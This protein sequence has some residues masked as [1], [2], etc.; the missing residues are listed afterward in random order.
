MNRAS[1]L[2][3]MIP[4]AE[5]IRKLGSP[6]YAERQTAT[7]APAELGPVALTQLEDAGKNPANLEAQRRVQQLVAA[8]AKKGFSRV[9]RGGSFQED[10]GFVRAAFRGSK[11]PT[12][13]YAN[14]GFRAVT[15]SAMR[16]GAAISQQ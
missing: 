16:G 6:T 11:N 3:S 14:V 5:L 15:D 9:V 4:F 7:K 13:G 12:E 10:A 2:L 8:F 1:W